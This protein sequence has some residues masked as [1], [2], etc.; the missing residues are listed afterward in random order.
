MINAKRSNNVPN[1]FGYSLVT[2]LSK[3]MTNSG[4]E[5]DD[6]VMVKSTEAE[7]IAVG[8]II[9][10]Y[11]YIETVDTDLSQIAQA[12]YS[13]TASAAYDTVKQYPAYSKISSWKLYMSKLF[14][15]MTYTSTEA[16]EKAIKANSSIIF[17]QVVEI[18][19]YDGYLWF[20][21]WGTSNV[22]SKGDPTYDTYWIREDYVIGR[23]THTS[24]AVRGFLS[25][26]STNSGILWMVEVPSGVHLILSTLEL[27][28]ILDMMTKERHERIKNG[29]YIDKK[30][31]KRLLRAKRKML[32][33]GNIDIES[34]KKMYPS[35]ENYDVIYS[36]E[37]NKRN[38]NINGPPDSLDNADDYASLYGNGVLSR[39]KTGPPP[40]VGKTGQGESPP[41]TRGDTGDKPRPSP[42]NTGPPPDV[43][44]TGQGESPPRTRGD[45][46][47][48]P[49]PS[50]DNT[51][52]PPDVG[53]TGQ[54]ESPPR[55]RG[56]TGDKN[57]SPGALST[58]T[59]R[60]VGQ[61]TKFKSKLGKSLV[62]ATTTGLYDYEDK[63]QEQKDLSDVKALASSHNIKV[64]DNKPL[65]KNEIL[66][67]NE[68]ID[69]MIDVYSWTNADFIAD[70]SITNKGV[71]E[72]PSKSNKIYLVSK[73]TKK[74]FSL[75]GLGIIYSV[76]TGLITTNTGIYRYILNNNGVEFE[77]LNVNPSY[78]IVSAKQDIF[79]NIFIGVVGGAK[80]EE[81]Y[82]TSDK[83]RVSIW[84]RNALLTLGDDKR[85][86][87]MTMSESFDLNKGKI[88]D[89]KVVVKD[90]SLVS[91]NLEKIKEKI[92]FVDGYEKYGFVYLEDG[93][94]CL[95]K[96]R[97][98]FELKTRQQF[99]LLRNKIWYLSENDIAVL[100]ESNT[101]IKVDVK[102]YLNILKSQGS[103]SNIKN[104]TV[105]AA[106]VDSV[107][108]DRDG[109]T[110]KTQGGK[111]QSI[112]VDEIVIREQLNT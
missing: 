67:S 111:T 112:K 5:I 60:D 55:T 42:D 83:K 23:Y 49:R 38:V 4:F 31:Y 93:I 69:R 77:K 57:S 68:E 44:K 3:S 85:L 82:F 19:D 33:S 91:V 45:T 97:L 73:R 39:D 96:G 7:D 90:G 1:I 29:T 105:L 70:T 109:L 27:V 6:S 89:L 76:N 54:G 79:G 28:E 16:S 84:N 80:T 81:V 86:Y 61:T 64:A 78:T 95:D 101:L 92:R 106:G 25:F 46:G 30:E 71:V 24:S 37:E 53:K 74:Q 17:H 13:D 103:L 8:D 15:N 36:F 32:A 65:G 50:P 52:P 18:V 66:L 59:D 51:G 11:K 88:T 47:D 56:D 12:S 110:I 40:D 100:D 2:I 87:Y 99:S 62:T 41:R 22:N 108:A 34:F 63:V 98:F 72:K 107:K 58:A 26:A 9:A 104:Q 10:Y 43:G 21:T 48:K 35:Y 14:S 75:D 94:L 102:D 20:R